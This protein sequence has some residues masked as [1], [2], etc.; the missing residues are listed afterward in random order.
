MLLVCVMAHP[1]ISHSEIVV[2]VN[3]ENPITQLDKETV[4]NIFLGRLTRFPNSELAISTIEIKGNNQ[5]KEL[6]YKL[7]ANK[8]LNKINRYWARYLFTGKM[9][10]PKKLLNNQAIVQEISNNSTGIAYIDSKDLTPEVK[11]VLT[12]GVE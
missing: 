8:T 1:Q 2:I 10:P 9:S 7:I 6:F 5:Q 4:K 3:A 12:L 11:I